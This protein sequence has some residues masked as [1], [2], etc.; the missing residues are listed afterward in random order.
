MMG[1][2][3][4]MLFETIFNFLEIRAREGAAL[5]FGGAPVRAA[6]AALWPIYDYYNITIVIR[7]RPRYDVRQ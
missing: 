3:F 2:F 5:P 7:R 6:S 4:E 1:F